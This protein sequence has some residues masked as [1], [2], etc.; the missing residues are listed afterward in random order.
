[1]QKLSNTQ[2]AKLPHQPRAG[3]RVGVI[4]YAGII[5]IFLHLRT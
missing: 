5:I 2:E 4:Q 1:M 3:G